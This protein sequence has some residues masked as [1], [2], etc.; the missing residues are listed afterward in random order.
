MG[1][2][3]ADFYFKKSFRGFEV[4]ENGCGLEGSI[5]S[6][7]KSVQLEIGVLG[8]VSHPFGVFM[9]VIELNEFRM[10]FLSKQLTVF[11]VTCTI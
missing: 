4:V 11:Q 1:D 10:G 2:N 3:K 8:T 9:Q 5:T 7:L 6:I